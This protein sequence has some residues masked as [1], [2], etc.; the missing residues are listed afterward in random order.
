MP[1]YGATGV[2]IDGIGADGAT[3][4]II[5]ASR[6]RLSIDAAVF[7]AAPTTPESSVALVVGPDWDA[8]APFDT[9]APAVPPLASDL[10]EDS[11]PYYLAL[12]EGKST[13]GPPGAID[14]GSRIAALL[15]ETPIVDWVGIAVDAPTQ[16]SRF[17]VTLGVTTL[18]NLGIES[19]PRPTVN[20]GDAST[21]ARSLS[22]EQG[23]DL[24]QLLIGRGGIIDGSPAGLQDFASSPGLRN[25][26]AVPTPEPG[27]GLL[28]VTGL[29]A[30]F[31]R[32]RR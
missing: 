1:Q 32:P 7:L 27:V 17:P 12:L 29:L 28:L 19:L 30:R 21:L 25:P 22:P 2:E 13:I 16:N 26:A 3:L 11:S 4:L 14:D 24:N 10:F 5:D 8:A 15:Q 31:R 23:P 6:T 9:P 20:T 18:L